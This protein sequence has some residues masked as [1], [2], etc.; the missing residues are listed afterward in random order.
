MESLNQLEKL[1]ER[2]KNIPV[3]VRSLD[4]S[5]FVRS[6]EKQE[7]RQLGFLGDI[8]KDLSGSLLNSIRS[9]QYHMTRLMA[10]SPLCNYPLRA[11]DPDPETLP[12][13]QQ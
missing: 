8:Y 2:V 3:P 4:S 6:S 13:K 9:V 12:R 11:V 10:A 7:G 5:G 1:M